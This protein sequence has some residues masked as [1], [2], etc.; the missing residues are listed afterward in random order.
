MLD[1]KAEP[2]R[3]VAAVAPAPAFLDVENS[4]NGR[5]WVARPAD[6]RQAAA[7]AQAWDLPELLGR[8]LAA[9]GV[10]LDQAGD[11]L[12]PTLR[13]LLPDPCHLKDMNRAAERVAQAICT[14]EPTAVFGDYDVDGATSSALLTRFFRAVGG[15]LITYIPDRVAEGYGP[16]LPALL[17]LR[18]RGIGL[19][20]TV[21]C[22][23]T[24]HLPLA[25]AA[26]AGLDVVVI[27]HH[28]AESALP[29]AVAVVNPNRI[30]EE[31]PHRTLAAVGVTFLLVI[32]VNRILRDR[33]WYRERPQPDLMRWL[34]LVALGTVCDVVPLV[35]LNRALVTQGLKVLRQRRNPGLAA[36]AD[37]AGVAE[38][39][40]SGH[41]GFIFG[42]RVNA[43]GRVGGADLGARLLSTDDAAEAQSLARQLDG[44]NVDRK[45]IEAAVLEQAI[46]QVPA[47]GGTDP[48]LFVAGEGWHPGV[49]GIVAARLKERF[50]RPACVIALEAG[51]GKASGRSVRG[52]DL[53]AAV[54]AA[55]QAGL[56]IAGGGHQ[57]A[58]GFT[59]A[60]ACLDPLRTFLSTWLKEHS[61]ERAFNPVLELDGALAL[62]GATTDLVAMVE[63]LAPYGSGN[64]EPRFAISDV[65][66]ARADVVGANHVRCFLTGLQGGRLKAI[67]FRAVDTELGQVLLNSQGRPLHIAGIL[68]PDRW[69]GAVG[70]QFQI[71]DA[72]LLWDARK[73]A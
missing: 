39:P 43:G 18:E 45:A 63:R 21:D 48:L 62:S 16:N 41:L 27:D 4:A 10:T 61:D 33:G 9:R 71:E 65:R 17:G 5:R 69:N 19:V 50:S 20:V 24:A 44:Y 70:V 59:V 35:G 25:G 28:A 53:G 46:A 52:V 12:N 47:D 26:T 57:M 30:D 49:V 15:T 55:R 2:R 64:P 34:D 68:R 72:F 13:A 8:V 54:I 40:D 32:A 14:G 58:A 6:P 29:L 1:G 66:I 51:I 60:L 37:V 42:P 38:P 56:L 73:T 23:T 22:G 67:A 7:L 11:F 31:S 3:A 36:L